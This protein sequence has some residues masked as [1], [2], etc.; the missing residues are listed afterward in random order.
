MSKLHI[1]ALALA[2]AFVVPS[3]ARAQYA[4]SVTSYN[5]GTG[6]AAG[7]TNTSAAVGAPTL[8]ASVTP[9]APPFAKTQLVS[10]GAGGEITMQFNT[11]IMNNPADPY[12]INF[13][14][15]AN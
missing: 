2:G 10:I 5:P 9:F 8:G 4:D 11:P 3:V 6:F 15:F 12:G 13:I 7:F 14:L 1:W